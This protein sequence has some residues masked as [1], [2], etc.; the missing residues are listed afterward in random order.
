MAL[1]T[2]SVV[3]LDVNGEIDADLFSVDFAAETIAPGSAA[4][5]TNSGTTQHQSWTIGVPQGEQGIQG[6]T[7]PAGGMPVTVPNKAVALGT[8]T[9]VGAYYIAPGATDLP[10]GAATGGILE[11]FTNDNAYLFQ[12]YTVDGVIAFRTSIDSG[13]T[14]TTWAQ[15]S[16]LVGGGTFTGD[17]KST[18]AASIWAPRKRIVSGKGAN[19]VAQ[20]TDDLLILTGTNPLTVTL[21]TGLSDKEITVYNATTVNASIVAGTGVTINGG[22]TMLPGSSIVVAAGPDGTVWYVISASSIIGTIAGSVAAG[23][24]PRIVAASH[25]TR[26]F[27][28]GGM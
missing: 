18:T 14:W 2:A 26:S 10:A 17:I 25:Y 28:L 6:A 20:S 12:I 8:L 11:V 4:T 23:N 22:T 24:D 27:L 7:G 19:Y 9:T 5:A 16:N 21:P 13:S 15:P 1:H 3:L